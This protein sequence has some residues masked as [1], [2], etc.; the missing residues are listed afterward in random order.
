MKRRGSRRKAVTHRAAFNLK[1]FKRPTRQDDLRRCLLAE[2][3]PATRT[4]RK[5]FETRRQARAEK[6]RRVRSLERYAQDLR[7]EGKREEA[8]EVFRFAKLLRRAKS[9]KDLPSFANPLF[10]REFRRRFSG[11]ILRLLRDIP[12]EEVRI[13]TIASPKWRLPAPKLADLGPRRPRESL[14]TSLIKAGL[15]QLS[16]WVIVCFHNEHDQATDTDQPHFHVVVVGEKYLAFEAL[17]ELDM[18]KSCKEVHHPIVCQTLV[19]AIRQISYLVKGYWL[20][21]FGKLNEKT[22]KVRR[23][24]QRR[25]PEPRHAESILFLHR[26]CFADLIWMHRIKIKGG[27]LVPEERD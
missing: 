13:Y 8:R 7:R 2:I 3:D 6:A 12:V 14:R 19:H 23:Y 26:Q 20:R 25:L 5:G 11:E 16:G 10:M 27:R 4:L 24:R 21:T 17:R 1:R 22:G 9:A 18:F 15:D